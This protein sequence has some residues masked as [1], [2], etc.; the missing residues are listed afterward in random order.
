MLQALAGTAAGITG[1]LLLSQLMAKML[2]GVHPTDPV[3]FGGVAIV[4]GLAALLATFIPALKA[5]HIEPI[6]ALRSE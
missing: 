2:Y 5:A 1:A 4:L 6:K 3:T